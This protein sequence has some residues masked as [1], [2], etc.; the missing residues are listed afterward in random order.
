MNLLV[1]LVLLASLPGCA[2]AYRAGGTSGQI[3]FAQDI[4]S[5][6]SALELTQVRPD[7]PP[8][9]FVRLPDCEAVAYWGDIQRVG[10]VEAGQQCLHFSQGVGTAL[11][12]VLI[13]GFLLLL[14]AL[15]F[16][17][18]LIEAFAGLTGG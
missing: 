10:L 2:P 17:G 1:G 14:P 7:T 18:M 16:F 4:F 5:R 11:G 13:L 12:G 3:Q 6:G 15:Q 9:Q 8:N